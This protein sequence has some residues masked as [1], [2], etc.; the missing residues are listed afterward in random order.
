MKTEG[1][2]KEFKIKARFSAIADGNAYE[3]VP[4]NELEGLLPPLVYDS[5][6]LVM[7]KLAKQHEELNQL[8]EGLA[9]LYSRLTPLCPPIGEFLK[10]DEI[11]EEGGLVVTTINAQILFVKRMCRNLEACLANLEI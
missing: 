5:N 2:A 6:S 9:C 7:S 10:D 11:S 4:K 3:S 1:K 8:Y